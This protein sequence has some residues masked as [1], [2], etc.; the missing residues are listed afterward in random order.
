MSF[1]KMSSMQ[2]ETP[3]SGMAS[4]AV[5]NSRDGPRF[6][7]RHLI[8]SQ[9]PID[10]CQGLS[11]DDRHALFFFCNQNALDLTVLL[12]LGSL[13]CAQDKTMAGQAEVEAGE[14]D[15]YAGHLRCCLDKWNQKP[16]ISLAT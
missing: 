4:G 12:V 10:T 9:S 1:L 7:S 14:A 16:S 8:A 6:G 3:V 11:E 13:R 15:G 5:D 2:I